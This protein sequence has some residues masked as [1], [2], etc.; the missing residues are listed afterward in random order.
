MLTQSLADRASARWVFLLVL[1][2]VVGLG[3][4]WAFIHHDYRAGGWGDEQDYE[5]IGRNIAEGHGYSSIYGRPTARRV[6]IVP[7]LV[8]A[9]YSVTPHDLVLARILWS[10]MDILTCLLI[11]YLTILIGG[12]RLAGL[13]AAA[14]FSLHPYFCFI[15]SHVL[16]ETPFALLFLASLTFMAA[17][18]R[19]NSWR[20]LCLSGLTMGLSMLARPTSFMFPLVIVLL[21]YLAYRRHRSP[22]R[23]KSVVYLFMAMLPLTPWAARNAVVF[24]S[25]V[26]LSTFGGVTLWCGSGA[27]EGGGLIIGPWRDAK[28]WKTMGHMSEVDSDR[29]LKREAIAAIRR[30]PGHWLKLGAIKFIRLWFRIPKPGW[31]SLLGIPLM[32]VNSS[33]LLL[34]WLNAKNSQSSILRQS[35]VVVFIY[36]CLLHMITYAE[37]RYS[38]PAYAY[39]LPF[40]SVQ[41]VDRLVNRPAQTIVPAETRSAACTT[42]VQ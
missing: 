27:T 22:W 26:P 7:F 8:A 35:I 13:I 39:F 12:S 37:L 24:K 11:F 1:I 42:S 4:R 29:Y 30:H 3:A 17:Y 36:Y 31:S 20:L 41:L 14:V 19:S 21:L 2:M 5:A 32:L 16:S 33:I 10:V 6:P 40:A 34:T 25:F 38:I 18:W 28:A 23:I 9:I 15:G